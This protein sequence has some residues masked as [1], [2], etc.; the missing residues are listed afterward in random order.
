MK[1]TNFGRIGVKVS[2]LDLGT[3]NLGGLVGKIVFKSVLIC[4]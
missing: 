2:R 1:M 3:M 4:G